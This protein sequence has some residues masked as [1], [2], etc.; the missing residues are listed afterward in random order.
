MPVYEYIC[1][2]CGQSF[3]KM[4]RFSE[5]NQTPS[6]PT[7]AGS[8]TKKKIS[9]FASSGNSINANTSTTCSSNPTSRFR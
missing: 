7:C 3:E 5:S 6:C 8:K 9:L 4:L 1:V 2:D